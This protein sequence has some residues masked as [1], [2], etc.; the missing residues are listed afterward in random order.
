MLI[1][2]CEV[3]GPYAAQLKMVGNAV[4]PLF[5]WAIHGAVLEA[6]T[7]HPAPKPAFLAGRPAYNGESS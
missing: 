6:A 3:Q 1:K 2:A 5:A 7:G 4:P